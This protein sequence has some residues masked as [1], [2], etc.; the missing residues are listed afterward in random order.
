VIC[1]WSNLEFVARPTTDRAKFSVRF[2]IDNKFLSFDLGGFAKVRRRSINFH[3]LTTLLAHS[4]G[5]YDLTTVN[6]VLETA[7]STFKDFENT[8]P[9]IRREMM[10]NNFENWLDYRDFLLQYM[11]MMRARSILFL[12]QKSIEGQSLLL[13]EI[14]KVNPDGMSVVL[15]SMEPSR[16]SAAFIRN[17]TISEM[18]AE[19]Q[20]GAGWL[21]DLDWAL[22]ICEY[23]DDGF[24][25]SENP[26]Q[27]YGS[28]SN[29][30][31]NAKHPDTLLFF[32]LCWQACLI[33]SRRPFD[34]K[35]S[36]FGH[37][38]MARF[39]RIYRQSAKLFLA[40]PQKFDI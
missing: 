5:M 19:I 18:R 7:D 40:S 9:R 38:D 34:V 32:P 25:T 17:W 11:Q 30:A 1:S 15:R 24:V 14:E 3:S 4:I 36:V 35:T 21:N 23:P 2:P 12:E 22:R 10:A 27:L 8:F 26:L 29:V 37:D 20:K 6:D 39:R 28:A 33:G 16:P 13:Y 31:E